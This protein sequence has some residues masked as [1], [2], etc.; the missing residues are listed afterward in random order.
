MKTALRF[1]L[2]LVVGENNWGSNACHKRGA[3]FLGKWGFS[4]CH[5]AVSKFYHKSY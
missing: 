2:G 1:A 3:P 4:L 5:T